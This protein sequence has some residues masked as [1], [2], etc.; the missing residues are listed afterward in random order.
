MKMKKFLMILGIMGMFFCAN[1]QHGMCVVTGGVEPT[2]T[3]TS[4]TCDRV[5]V[6][7]EN[8]NPYKV[9]V[10][11]DATIVDKEG[12]EVKREKTVVIPANKKDK[13]V[14][15]KTKSIKGETK[16]ADLGEC[17]VSIRVEK[18]E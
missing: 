18:C 13:K 15:F 12:N 2:I 14:Y 5:E 1:A 16:C 10:T 9:T 7:L 17:S 6:N 4:G 11:I 3:G 8:T